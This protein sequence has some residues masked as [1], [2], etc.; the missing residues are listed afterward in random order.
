LEQVEVWRV[1]STVESVLLHLVRALLLLRSRF[2][3][4]DVVFEA[5]TCTVVVLVVVALVVVVNVVVVVRAKWPGHLATKQW[6][7]RPSSD[8]RLLSLRRTRF[9]RLLGK[10]ECGVIRRRLHVSDEP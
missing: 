4:I 1:F 3:S 5:R 7:L 10:S 6:D 9:A 8:R 2:L